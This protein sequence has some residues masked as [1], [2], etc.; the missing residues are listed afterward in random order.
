MVTMTSGFHSSTCSIET[1]ASPPRR[2][3]GD[4]AR[5]QE[6]DR[7]DVDRAAEPGLEPARPARVIDARPLLGSEFRGDPLRDRR[8]R[9]VGIA[10]KR[11]G[12]VAA[13]DQFAERAIGRG[14]LVETAVEQRVGNAGLLLHAI[15]ERNVGRVGVAD[16]ENEIGLE[17]QHRFEIGGVAAPGEAAD[18]RPGA[19][20]G[21]QELALLGRLAR[22]QPSSR[23]GA[24]V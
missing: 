24:S 3:A 23:S 15:G 16:V 5:A 17:R 1:L 22:G 14:G 12:F 13:A 6:L 21:Q 4:V 20:V 10:R 2:S 19:D 8:H 7:L 9:V 11:L 18:F